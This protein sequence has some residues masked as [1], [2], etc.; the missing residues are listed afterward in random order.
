MMAFLGRGEL[1]SAFELLD[2]ELGTM[3]VEAD[4][5]VVG[6]AAMAVAYDARRGL[7]R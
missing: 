6:G 4:P 5:F 2:D 3:G 1:L 7:R